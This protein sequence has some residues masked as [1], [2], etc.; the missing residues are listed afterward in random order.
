MV[1]SHN[2]HQRTRTAYQLGWAEGIS[3]RT[4]AGLGSCKTR[5][6]PALSVNYLSGIFL[7]SFGC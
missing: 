6:L 4:G 1:D 7:A 5:Q 3:K 2:R